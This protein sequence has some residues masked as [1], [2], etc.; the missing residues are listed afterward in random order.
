MVLHRRHDAHAEGRVPDACRRGVRCGDDRR[1]ACRARRAGGNLFCALPPFDANAAVASGL[2]PWLAG[3]HVVLGPAGGY[4]DKSLIANFWGVV[5]AHRINV[6][7]GVPAFFGALLQS[8]TAGKD[9]SSLDLAICGG[10]RLP[11]DLIERFEQVTG[12]RTL[13][14]CL[15]QVNKC[16]SADGLEFDNPEAA[17]QRSRVPT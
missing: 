9:L 1:G 10:A 2:A 17:L 4:R 5:E 16:R 13:D 14:A 11:V 15:C 7:S 12:I 3:S 8:P 6:L